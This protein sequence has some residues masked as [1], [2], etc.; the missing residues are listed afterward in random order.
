MVTIMTENCNSI[1]QE[2][3]DEYVN[4]INIFSITCECGCTGSMRKHGHYIR[5]VR[6]KGERIKLSIQRIRCEKCGQTHALLISIIV[7]YS[8]ITLEDHIQIIVH[9]S[10]KEE[11]ESILVDNSRIDD[12][13]VYRI[14][15][16]F[17]N[18]WL[19]RLLATGL[20]ILSASITEV[21][22]R[23]YRKQF[24]QIHLGKVICF[25]SPT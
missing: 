15:A 18:H 17:K 21:C 3:Y 25:C 19:Q 9:Q 14:I 12:S 11:L 10:S 23:L 13:E 7:P 24:M 4:N 22:I 20:D 8:Q 6:F 5:C 2:I 1:S 16:N